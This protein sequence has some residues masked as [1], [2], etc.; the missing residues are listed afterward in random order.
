M[1]GVEHAVAVKPVVPTG[2]GVLGVGSVAHIE[3]LEIERDLADH[4]EVISFDLGVHRSVSAQKIGV[5][6]SRAR[7]RTSLR[8]STNRSSNV[9]VVATLWD[10]LQKFN[11]RVKKD[12]VS[13]THLRAH[14]TVLD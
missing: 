2:G 3:T 10:R 1:D 11:R 6:L 8:R 5:V 7:L 4:R 13:Y 12:P 14:E 9:G